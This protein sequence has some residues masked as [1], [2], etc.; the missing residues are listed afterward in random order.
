MNQYTVTVDGS[1]PIT[2][3]AQSKS[4]AK[5]KI[6][7]EGPDYLTEDLIEVTEE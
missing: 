6:L 2:T 7:N 4:A 3:E 5:Q 1:L